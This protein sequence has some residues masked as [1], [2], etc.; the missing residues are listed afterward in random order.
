LTGGSYEAY[1]RAILV[2]ACKPREE[3][4]LGFRAVV[5][6]FRGCAG[7][8]LTSPQLYSAGHTDD[9]R[10]ALIY[11][12]KMYPRAPLLGL[13]YSLGANVMTR[14]LA[15]EGEQSRLVSGCALACPW[16]LAKNSAGLS[17]TVA[18]KYVYSRGMGGNLLNLVKRHTK[19]L[20]NFPDH[21]VAKAV[22]LVLA[23]K[24]PTLEQFDETFTR[25]AGGSAPNFPFPTAKDYYDWASSHFV[26]KDLRV[27]FLAINSA[28][29]PVVQHVP[30]N[31]GGNG[32]VVMALTPSGGHL[33]W[34]QAAPGSGHIER[35]ITKPVLEWLELVGEDIVHDN[36]TTGRRIYVDEDGFLKEEGRDHLGCKEIQGP[37]IIDGN[38]GEEGLLQGL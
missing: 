32:L 20:L 2:P 5:V 3:G 4:G 30:M 23:L 8:P 13:G 24:N 1:V 28:D 29:D 38:E 14:Y 26:L 21:Q 11:I 37:G 19:A 34:F 18:G 10:Q 15:E 31:G 6:N 35:W 27:P 25:I 17:S 36:T 7:V 16:D 33:G 22:P 12:T 9:L